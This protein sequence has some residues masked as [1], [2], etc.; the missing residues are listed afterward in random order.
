[1][2]PPPDQSFQWR[3]APQAPSS[4]HQEMGQSADLTPPTPRQGEPAA[5]TGPQK[6]PVDR[7]PG[8]NVVPTQVSTV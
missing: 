7:A 3:S 5:Q 2:S 4:C 6:Y 8:I 1:V